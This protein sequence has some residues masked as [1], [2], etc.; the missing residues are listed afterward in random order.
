MRSVTRYLHR[1]RFRYAHAHRLGG[2]IHQNDAVIVVA[3]ATIR[4]DAIGS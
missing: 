2:E 3:V 1:P 4:H